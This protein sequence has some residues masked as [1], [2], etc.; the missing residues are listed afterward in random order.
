MK[1][2]LAQSKMF[3]THSQNNNAKYSNAL[4]LKLNM[5]KDE[6]SFGSASFNQR[7]LSRKKPGVFGA[8]GWFFGGEDSAK[9]AVT[10]E[11]QGEIE[12]ARRQTQLVEAVRREREAA[13]LKVQTSQQEAFDA[14]NELIETLKTSEQ[15]HQETISH[16]NEIVATKEQLINETKMANQKLE[17][18][19]EDQKKSAQEHEANVQKMVQQ[20]KEA[21]EQ[22]NRTLQETLSKQMADL[23]RVHQ[24]EMQKLSDSI[25][26]ASQ[27][28]EIFEKM[29]DLNNAKGFGKIAGYKDQKNILLDHFGTPIALER[30]GKP[31]DVPGGILFFGPKGNGKTT[32]AEAFAGQL[33]CELVRVS[34]T[35]D[36]KKD[37]KALR[38]TAEQAQKRFSKE[39]TRTIILINEFDVFAPK[40]SKITGPLKDLMD[41]L[42][43]D[44]HATLF[45]TTNYPEK[46]DDVLLRDGR[47][48]KAGLPVS[49]KENAT[50]VLEHYAKPYASIDVN[51]ATLAEHITS[52]QPDSAFS[53]ARIKSVVTNIT[54]S[55]TFSGKLTQQALLDSI[56]KLGADIG[57]EA[58]E[59]FKNQVKYVRSL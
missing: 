47:F 10:Y 9:Q 12:D 33:D 15:K 44:Y 48:F 32:F 2:D 11:M 40:D 5:P 21:K 7:V 55:K 25:N 37:L 18:L 3:S 26:K 59:T 30:D 39:K 16:L 35:L 54:E 1:V 50:A 52:V 43:K 22:N 41:R 56:K 13:F 19:Y 24:A 38:A 45:P 51:Y 6:V 58:L 46:I 29:A 20:M 49:D 4:A 36:P 14:Q 17:R 53:N 28:A 42:S 8:I 31:A 27:S 23:Q 34:S 57:K